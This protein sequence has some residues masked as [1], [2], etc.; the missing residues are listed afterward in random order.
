MRRGE[1]K[2]LVIYVLLSSFI[3]HV[4]DFAISDNVKL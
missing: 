1:K 2:P 3:L 4:V